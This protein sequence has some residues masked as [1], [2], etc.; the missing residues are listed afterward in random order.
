[1][2]FSKAGAQEGLGTRLGVY[3]NIYV[4]S[5]YVCMHVSCL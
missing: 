1:M 2:T 3:L 4:C 5:L